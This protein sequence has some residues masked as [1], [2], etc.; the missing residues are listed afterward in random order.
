MLG[1]KSSEKKEFKKCEIDA[2]VFF[3]Y[4]SGNADTL[5]Y[6]AWTLIIVHLIINFEWPIMDTQAFSPAHTKQSRCDI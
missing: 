5:S 2:N 1:G 4:F 3:K 6:V